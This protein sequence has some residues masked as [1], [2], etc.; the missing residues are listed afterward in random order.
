[1]LEKKKTIIFFSV[2]VGLA[3]II[4]S[5]AVA[6]ELNNLGFK[7]IYALPKRKWPLVKYSKLDFIDITGYTEKDGIDF[8]SKLDDL[9]YLRFRV[10]EERRILRKF[11]PDC[12][13]IDFRLTAIASCASFEV[14]TFFI[15]GSGGLPYGCYLPNPGIPQIIHKM[16]TP[17]VQKIVWNVKLN[18]L[19]A[20][21][22]VAEEFGEKIDTKQLLQRM[23]Y[24]IPEA[25][26]YLPRLD[27]KL[28]VHYVGPLFWKGFKHF[29][30][31]WIKDIKTSGR[32]VYLTFGGTGFDDRKM[33][34]ISRL[35][36]ERDFTVVVSA[37][38][39]ADIEAFPKHRR[40]FVTEYLSGEEI[41]KRVDLIVC[42]GG[43][44]T[45][46][47][48]VL[49][50]KPI[51]AVPFNLDQLLHALRFQELG[52]AKCMVGFDL[53]FTKNLYKMNWLSFQN[54]G[55]RISS[56]EIVD[57][58]EKVLGEVEKYRHS[59]TEFKRMLDDYNGA[60]QAAKII[61][62]YLI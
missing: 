41:C 40:L 13:V 6:E 7:V 39:I 3:H 44:G 48:A 54:A 46:M 26:F 33:I 49:A 19:K 47:E 43:Y 11:R 58:A 61:E 55:S 42:H 17:L 37:S 45:M 30:P 34:S 57:T 60:K 12:I 28:T 29:A 16:I 21:K 24:L 4:R 15:T 50:E 2:E 22:K 27:K 51:V 38:N 14:P 5:L 56:A 31:K 62:K 8:I 53:E 23:I 9:N 32:T 25:P 18:Y 20:I 59:A 36:L 10:S 35:L 1:M 52:L